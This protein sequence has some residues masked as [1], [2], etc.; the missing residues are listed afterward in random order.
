MPSGTQAQSVENFAQIKVVGVGGGGSVVCAFLVEHML[1]NGNPP[2]SILHMV[3]GNNA[4]HGSPIIN[5]SYL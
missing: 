3:A 2:R 4:V 5:I 1:V